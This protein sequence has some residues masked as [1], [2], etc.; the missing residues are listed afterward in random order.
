M[1]IDSGSTQQLVTPSGDN[2]VSGVRTALAVAAMQE[3]IK[4]ASAWFLTAPHMAGGLGAQMAT[5]AA[6]L[7]DYKARLHV[8]YLANDILLKACAAPL[9]HSQ[10][11]SNELSRRTSLLYLQVLKLATPVTFRRKTQVVFTFKYNLLAVIFF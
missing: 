9:L 5:H 3:S 7:A 10:I 6:G 11:L 4:S 2:R 1:S 8:L